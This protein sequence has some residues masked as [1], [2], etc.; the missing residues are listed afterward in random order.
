MPELVE[1][2]ETLPRE[3]WFFV[4]HGKLGKGYQPESF[5]NWFKDQCKAAGLPQCSA[6]GLR[7]AGATELANKGASEFEIM[8]YLGHKTPDEARTYVKAADRL[9]LTDSALKKRQNVSNLVTR[10]DYDA[11]KS[12]KIKGE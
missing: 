7:K 3:T 6:H 5:G 12:L 9:K 4:T 2:L 11:R 10:L 8:A 1:V